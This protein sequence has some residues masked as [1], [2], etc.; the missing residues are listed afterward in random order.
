VAPRTART[1]TAL[2]DAGVTGFHADVVESFERDLARRFGVKHALACNNGTAAAFSAFEALGVGPGHN[3]IGPAISHWASVLP[4]ARCGAELVLA[5][6]SPGTCHVDPAAVARLIDR[7]TRAVVVTHMFGDVR[8]LSELR[9]LCDARRVA[10]VEDVSH[11]HGA[12]HAGRPAGSHGDVSFCSFQAAKL[13]SGGEGGALLT[14]RA[15]IR[16]RALSLA[17]PRR[18]GRGAATP[19]PL[20]GVGRGFKFQPSALLV[21]LAHGSLRE[22]D[23]QTLLRRRACQLLRALLAR[24]GL[25]APMATQAP[26]RSYFRCELQ[27]AD[28]TGPALRDLVVRRLRAS[29]VRADHV[30]GFL[31]DH[32]ALRGHVRAGA[33]P[34]ARRVMDRV[35]CLEPF[36]V[37][38]PAMVRAYAAHVVE[39]VRACRAEVTG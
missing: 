2:L 20:A 4:A 37:A 5:D 34:E 9:R 6:V 14:D 28:A 13:V 18:L 26:G 27:V 38:A 16:D 19:H 35:F 12:V 7:R 33:W 15:D 8:G 24:S 25:F 11:A 29:G 23:R 39:I 36:T 10:L 32:P 3:V 1:V 17:H 22:L 31:P 21:G 30:F